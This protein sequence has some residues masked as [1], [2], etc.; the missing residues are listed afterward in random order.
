MV[1]IVATCV[2][3]AH[4]QDDPDPGADP[5]ETIV[6]EDSQPPPRPGQPSTRVTREE[7]EDRQPRSVPDALRWEPGVYVQQTSAA[8]GSPFVRGRTGQQTILLFDGIRLNNS[9][10]R[11]GPNQYF[12]T[13]DLRTVDR[14]EVT[15]GGAS[16]LYGSDAIAGVLDAIPVRPR[17]RGYAA[18]P[19]I[20]F[21]GATA[22]GELGG[23]ARLDGRVGDRWSYVG[24]VGY[25]DIGLLESGG[26]VLS[27]VTGEPP[28]VPRFDDD[29]RTQLGTGFRELAAD[30]RVVYRAAPRVWITT[31]AYAYRQLDAPRTDQCPPPYAPI[32]ECLTYDEQFHTLAYVAVDATDLWLAAS[33]QHQRERR[34]RDRP[35]SNVEHGGRDEVVTFG[36]AGKAATPWRRGA[37]L[38]YG[39]DLY[40]D[41]VDSS[42]WTILTDVDY[43]QLHSRGQYLAGSSYAT[44]GAF[45][46][47]E[48]RLGGELTLRGGARAS[49]ATASSPADAQSGTAAIDETWV[50]AVADLGTEWQLDRR[51]AL[52]AHLDR[53]F[54]APNL[55][56]L[57]ARQATGPGF[58]FENPALEPE[59]A[60]SLDLGTRVRAGRVELEL[61]AYGSALLHAIARDVRASSDCPP[62]TPACETAWFRYQL[63]NLDGVALIV[64]VDGHMR[65]RLPR[66]LTARATVGYARGDGPNPQDPDERLPLSRIPPLHGTA[67]LSWAGGPWRLAG[68]LRWATEQDR[69]ATSDRSDERIPRGGTPG[70][71]VLEARAGYRA[72]DRLRI[73]VVFENIT[74]AAYR[75]HGSSVNGPARG[76][77]LSLEVGL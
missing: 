65:V 42:A 76:L 74:D 18:R 11:Q 62:E 57:T 24:G 10:Y 27:P 55:D 54:R 67:E 25:R 60:Y 2:P 56:D 15:R 29:G 28:Q 66:G 48:L 5:D 21:R 39:G 68:G 58:Q 41:R 40:Y 71:A 6:V 75:Y 30:G 50:T 4:A 72:G 70:F 45:A 17:P 46:R 53:S 26:L 52:F 8:Q 19:T 63:V 51:V 33:V 32:T 7:L 1:A 13:I 31:A 38:L 34:T 73:H 16:T 22:D 69:L 49:A 61:W 9:L 12:F 14:I 37:R 23:R 3:R 36:L 35:M 47:G 44:G 59:V 20:S 64:G 77:T 43:V